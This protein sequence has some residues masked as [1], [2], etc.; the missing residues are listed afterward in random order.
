MSRTATTLTMLLAATH[1]LEAAITFS[2]LADRT[3]YSDTVTFTVNPDPNAAATTATLDG[4]PITVGT[5]ITVTQV[6]FHEL[7]AESRDAGGA[8]VDSRTMR[9]IVRDSDRGS[10]EDG[11]PPHTPFKMVNDAPSAF[12]GGTLKVVAPAAWPAGLPV[13]IAAVLRN[14]AGE[15]LRLNGVVKMSGF[16]ASP[17][18]LRR[19]WG[20]VVAPAVSTPGDVVVGAGVNGVAHSPA[21]SIEA[22]PVFTNVSGA[23]SSNTAWP[24]NSRIRVTG[25]LT[26]AAGATLTIGAG[27][28]VLVDTGTGSNGSAAE[29]V[30]NGTLRSQGVDG[31]PVV[32][33]PA[34]AGGLWGGIE[35][36][37]ATSFVEAAH[38]IFTGAGEDETWFDTHSGYSTHKPQQ[39]LFLVAGSGTGT[40]I[41]AQLHLT[42]CYC[43]SLA[44]QLMNSRTNTW[45]DLQRTLVQRA[46]TSG[47][48]NGSRVTID[49]CALIEFPGES[50]EFADADNDAIYLTNGELT[51]TNNVLGFS[52]DDGI[53]SGGNGGDNPYTAAADVTPLVSTN[54]WFESSFHESNSLSG[55]R[56]VTHTGCVFFNSGQGVEAGYSASGTGNGPHVIIDGCL[57][58]T[59]MVGVRW[60]DNYGS[61]YQYN[62]SAEVK[63]SFLLNSLFHDAWSYD[64]NDWTY[65]TTQTNSFGRPRFDVHDNW[66]SQ[67]DPVNHPANTAWNPALHG[68]LIQPFMPVPGSNVGVAVTSYDAQQKTEDYAGEFTVRLSTFSSKAVAVGYTVYGALPSAFQGT[69]LNTGTLTF[70]PGETVKVAAVPIVAPEQY[71]YLHVVLHDPVNAEVTGHYLY[72]SPLS[73]A[74]APLTLIPFGAVWKYLD[75]GSNQGTAWRG[76]GYSDASWASGPGELG[77]GDGEDTTVGFVDVNPGM[78]GVQKN[79]TTYFRHTVNVANPELIQTLTLSLLYDDGAVIYLNGARVGATSGMPVDPA[80]DFYLGSTSANNATQ[81]FVLQNPALVAGPNVFAVEIHQGNNTSGDISF[82]LQATL[83]FRTP[84][85][86]GFGVSG[87]QPLLWWHDPNA[88]LERSTDFFNWTPMPGT[89]SPLIITPGLEKEFWRLAR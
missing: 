50:A 21:V 32:F 3:K 6:R 14:G 15:G 4:A 79:A 12:A 37:V 73:G 33:A 19:G 23:I 30:V 72:V 87:G 35:M 38:T 57:F 25:T 55:T 65:Y 26:I 47:Q 31:S 64:W 16:P 34:T 36:P 77:Y 46:I 88:L 61:G 70:L 17:I 8:L 62:A 39:A 67:P 81:T 5:P 71:H 82:D 84:L 78:S 52:K 2:G 54:N 43:F 41:G 58:A 49:R 76:V 89:M 18:Q 48:L 10:S 69:A 22:A 80:F 53:D 85:E 59:N 44:G 63:N 45:I 28:I 29:I 40:G 56:H 86:L 7:K 60:G 75:D 51:L 1:A 27:S 74:P 42:D 13:P 83:T 11:L 68:T 9:F 66:L 24:A 20:S